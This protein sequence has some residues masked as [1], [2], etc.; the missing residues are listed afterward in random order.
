[1]AAVSASSAIV[2]ALR[3]GLVPNEGLEHFATGLDPLALAVNEE[4]DFVSG[5]KGLSKWIR[6]EY[7]T[8]KTF[9]A[10]HLCARARQRRFA[11]VPA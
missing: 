6:G 4:L 10:R 3:S 2:N 11:S 5:G 9:A 1:M 8:G 7:G